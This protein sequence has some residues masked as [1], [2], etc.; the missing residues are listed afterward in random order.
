MSDQTVNPSNPGADLLSSLLSAFGTLP[1]KEKRKASPKPKAPQEYLPLP[2]SFAQKKT[3]YRVWKATARVLQIQKQ[4]CSCCGGEIEYVKAEFFSLENGTAHATWLRSEAYGIEAP[5][6]LP[7]T[8]VDLDPAYV[9][10]CASCR[11]TP[12][13]DLEALFHPKQLEFIL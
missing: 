12:F 13:D 9:P 4:I 1:P 5:E 10:G 3:G 6:S 2:I 7:I 8:Y 11:T